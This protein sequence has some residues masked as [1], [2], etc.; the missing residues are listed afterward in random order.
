MTIRVMFFP[1]VREG[2]GFVDRGSPCTNVALDDASLAR[3][4]IAAT[5]IAP[6]APE[7]WM[8]KF[9][10]RAEQ[11]KAL[12]R[13]RVLAPAPIVGSAA[14]A[15]GPVGSKPRSP[16]PLSRPRGPRSIGV[17]STLAEEL[18]DIV[19]RPYDGVDYVALDD[20]R[21]TMLDPAN[22][23]HPLTTLGVVAQTP[24]DVA[25][26]HNLHSGLAEVDVAVVA[27]LKAHHVL[28]DH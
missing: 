8:M 10:E 14:A 12:L 18:F 16:C 15:G 9:A 28:H 4:A 11:P 22:S 17:L 1:T 2:C 25:A 19:G 5:R 23:D 7:A 13:G 26:N 20:V 27:Q 21:E 3:L 24:C 6:T